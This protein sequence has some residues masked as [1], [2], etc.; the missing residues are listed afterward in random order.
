MTIMSVTIS[1]RLSEWLLETL[2]ALC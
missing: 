2:F 1:Q